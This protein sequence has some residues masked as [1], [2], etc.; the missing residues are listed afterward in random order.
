MFNKTSKILLGF[1]III[2]CVLQTL[3]NN[4]ETKKHKTIRT[5]LTQYDVN[6]VEKKSIEIA[7]VMKRE[8]GNCSDINKLLVG[9]S[10]LNRQDHSEFPN[11]VLNV[12]NQNNQYAISD[13][14]T[15]QDKKLAICLLEG[16][17]RD[18][19]VLYFYNPKTATDK[20][21]LRMMNKKDL[22]AKTK[23]HEYR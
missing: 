4:I 9:S 18:C 11:T 15:E 10:I 21:F 3:H 16:N 22:I 1:A 13:T 5:F 2:G 12:I 17:F 8:C 6:K 20:S 23:H 19:E 7:K 14:Y